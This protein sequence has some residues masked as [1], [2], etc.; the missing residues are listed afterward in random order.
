VN[1]DREESLKAKEN[2]GNTGIGQLHEL[3][4]SELLRSFNMLLCVINS[5][6]FTLTLLIFLFSQ[7]VEGSM[8][9]MVESAALGQRQWSVFF[10]T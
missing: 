10:R 7:C 2:V 8:D 1:I 3:L 5:Q 4:P 9:L 6:E